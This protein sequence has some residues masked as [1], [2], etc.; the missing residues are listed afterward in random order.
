LEIRESSITPLIAYNAA[1]AKH[2]I[3]LSQQ[4]LDQ[5]LKESE[6]LDEAE[7]TKWSVLR[8]TFNMPANSQEGYYELRPEISKTLEKELFRGA[9][10][11]KILSSSL[12]TLAESLPDLVTFNSSIVDQMQWERVAG[13][14]LT[15]ETVEAECDLF[16]IINDFFCNAIIPPITGATFP[17]SYQLLASDLATF[18]QF[19]YPLALGLPRL[20]PL[21]GLP[22][23]MLA[24]KRLLKNFTRLFEELTNPPQKRVPDDDESSSGEE[25]D[26]D[27]PTPFTALNEL[28]TKHDVPVQARAAIALHLLH[29]IYS[30]VVP[31]ACWTIL[32]IHQQSVSTKSETLIEL[33][34]KETRIW[35]EAVQ[36]PSI[37]PSFPAPPE[38]RFLDTSKAVAPATFP[39]LRSCIN[40]SRRL[41][42]SS[43]TTLKLTKPITLTELESLRP[44]DPDK[45]ELDAHSYIDI[46]LSHTLIN[47]SSANFLTPN[48]YQPDR[49]IHTPAPTSVISPHEPLT[50]AL[51]LAFIAGTLQ[52]WDI[53][54]APRKS[55]RDQMN[56][57][58]AAAT[59]EKEPTASREK[60]TWIVPKAGDGGVV[61]VPMGEIRV[62]IRRREGLPERNVVRKGRK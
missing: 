48:I 51:L 57:V 6:S 25:T 23:A 12:T 27:T 58:T 22:G 53:S 59:G 32:H 16:T 7:I 41:Y 9:K 33:I 31:L 62:R 13:L 1:G 43:V 49:F 60:G 21:P 8:N 28:F 29:T 10:M 52:L 37:H 40:E 36:P 20:Y 46:G 61:K 35:A 17:E 42:K 18:N 47:T 3:I 11:E 54:A 30:E 38:I 5:L 24:K 14:D 19:F 50:T 15:E 44:G 4:L 34:V 45:W 55:F 56:E 39:L 26:A 2:N